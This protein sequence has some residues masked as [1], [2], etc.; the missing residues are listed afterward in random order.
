[1]MDAILLHLS[2]ISDLR[3]MSRT[4][5]EQY[6]SSNKT[7]TKICQ[8]QNVNYLL[9]GS[10]QWVGDSIKLI[11]QLIESG[12]ERHLWAKGYIKSQKDVLSIQ[13]EVARTI[14][15]EIHAVITP[16]EKQRIEKFPTLNLTAY[17]FYQKAR[18]EHWKFWIDNKNVESLKIA[19]SFY[20]KALEYDSDYAESFSGLANIFWD[21]N[22][23]KT[24]LSNTFLVSAMFFAN[25]ALSMKAA[26]LHRG[27]QLPNLLG[28]LGFYLFSAGFTEEGRYYAN[29]AFKITCDSLVYFLT[30]ASVEGYSQNWPANIDYL[31]K[32]YKVDSTY[33]RKTN[34]A[35]T[36]KLYCPRIGKRG[37]RF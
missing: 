20:R 28:G 4:S 5:V 31:L 33:R 23:I 13:N 19:E 18:E 7:D 11:F 3:V 21:K 12:K 24:Y 2:G 35:L 6:R 1:M 29:E 27:P 34:R 10:F 26:S 9:E 17:D 37:C 15:D 25:K 14:A 22:F 32:A 8:E 30:L 16:E 36:V